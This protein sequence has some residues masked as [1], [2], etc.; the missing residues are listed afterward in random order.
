[1]A[2]GTTRQLLAGLYVATEDSQLD[3][4]GYKGLE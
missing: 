3:A 2:N 4:I 1:M